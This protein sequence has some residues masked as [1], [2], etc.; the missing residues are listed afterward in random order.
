MF[1]KIGASVGS[2]GMNRATDV[3]TVQVLLNK[4]RKFLGQRLI[5][6]D[7][8]VREDG[9][10]VRAIRD[11]QMSNFG[12]QD[13]RVDAGGQTLDKLN[14]VSEDLLLDPSFHQTGKYE[15][16][17]GADGEILVEPGDWLSKYSAAI[18]DN[19]YTINV[20]GR[21]N[22]DGKMVPVRNVNYIRAFESLY[23]VPTYNEYYGLGRYQPPP[24]TIHDQG[25][26]TENFAQ[27]EFNLQGENW[28]EFVKVSEWAERTGKVLEVGEITGVIGETGVLAT[29]NTVL[30]VA[31]PI[32][33]EAVWLIELENALE[34]TE[35]LFGLRAVAYGATAWAFEEDSPQVSPELLRRTSAPGCSTPGE[36]E[37]CKRAW[38]KAV[39][40]IEESLG[41]EA[42]PT[43][44]PVSA[45]TIEACRAVIKQNMRESVR[46]QPKE[47]CRQWM[48][49]LESKVDGIDLEAWKANYDIVYPN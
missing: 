17:V 15:V 44:P 10:T 47:L 21:L 19:F 34:G 40:G 23:H 3:K 46:N 28:E 20:F 38:Q 37:R 33:T 13:G 32:L 27:M 31:G 4:V 14:E 43:R 5:G 7:G 24:Q 48:I 36:I 9:E 25:Q 42:M 39:E 26:V 1:R 12:W 49:A 29:A 18:Y 11:F 6:V 22:A 16:E 35:K 45:R 8:Y 30:G 2:G 41:E